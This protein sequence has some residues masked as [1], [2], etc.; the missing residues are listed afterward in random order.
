MARSGIDGMTTNGTTGAHPREDSPQLDGLGTRDSGI[1]TAG[2]SNTTEVSGTDSRDI[3]GLDT[4]LPFQSSQQ[5]QEARKSADLS[6]CSRSGDSLPPSDPR[7]FQDAELDQE[8]APSTTTG[9]IE[10]PVTSLEVNS[11]TK[12]T[13]SVKL[14]DPISGLELSDAS[15]VQSYTNMD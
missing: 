13:L 3:S 6:T 5:Y 9:K 15:E 1:T 7:L 14:A 12:R 10:L 11:F 4:E 2:S 8:E